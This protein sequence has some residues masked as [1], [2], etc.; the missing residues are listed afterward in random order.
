MSQKI[1]GS[2]LGTTCNQAELQNKQF[3]EQV[4]IQDVKSSESSRVGCSMV[5]SQNFEI[6]CK[7]EFPKVNE[8]VVD[9]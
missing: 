5:I 8:S 2:Q 6:A 7:T 1:D 4:I 9:R 3:T